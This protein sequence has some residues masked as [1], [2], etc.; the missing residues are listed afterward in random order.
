MREYFETSRRTHAEVWPAEPMPAADHLEAFATPRPVILRRWEMP[1]LLHAITQGRPPPEILGGWGGDRDEVV[2]GGPLAG[3]PPGAAPSAA[4]GRWSWW[5]AGGRRCSASR[6]MRRWTAGGSSWPRGATTRRPR[7]P[8][9]RPIRASGCSPSSS[10]GAG[11]R[12][13]RDGSCPGPPA[14]A[15]SLAMK[16]VR[17]E[18]LHCDGGWRP[19]AFVRGQTDDRLLGSGECND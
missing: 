3:P 11:P 10:S 13:G 19:R 5:G 12:P 2:Q 17:V 1:V 8:P 16:I 7:G 15:S 4:L 14:V 18:A 9:R 6:F